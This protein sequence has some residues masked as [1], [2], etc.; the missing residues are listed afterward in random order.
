M[1]SARLRNKYP[2][3]QAWRIHHAERD[4]YFNAPAYWV[5]TTGVY[6]I[7]AITLRVMISAL[8]PN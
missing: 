5:E 1:I 3:P 8:L 2:T 6:K 7:V 4:G